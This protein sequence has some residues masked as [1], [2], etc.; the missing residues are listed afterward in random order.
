MYLFLRWCP[1]ALGILLRQK[2]YRHLLKTCGRNVLI[3]RYVD[4][5]NPQGIIIGDDV[6]LNEYACLDAG[7]P[8]NLSDA[9]IILGKG[10]FI[11]AGTTLLAGP[12]RLTIEEGNNI[13]SSCSIAASGDT[14]L[15]HHAL[16]A[17]F[18]TVGTTAPSPELNGQD[19]PTKTVT[20]GRTRLG[21]GCWLGL[22]SRVA[23]GIE[24]GEGTIVGAHSTVTE[25]LPDYVIAFGQP[26]RV[27]RMR[28]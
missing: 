24:I 13:G 4:L 21:S 16:L 7:R 26:A 11:G 1:G 12:G 3:G 17:G 19:I 2:L 8:G 23:P 10:V 18:C 6:I 20:G 25:S 22:R 9:A 14:I 5:K 28:P 27:R 15:E